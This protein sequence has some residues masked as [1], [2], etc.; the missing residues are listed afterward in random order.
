MVA[1][2]LNEMFYAD[3]LDLSLPVVFW[4]PFLLPD[5]N[6]KYDCGCL[7][8]CFKLEMNVTIDFFLYLVLV[9]GIPFCCSFLYSP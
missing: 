8:F 1:Q 7:S 3:R 6:S 9:L 2:Y 5:C 4:L